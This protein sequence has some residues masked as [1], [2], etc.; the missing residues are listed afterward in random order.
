[1]F[2]EIGTYLKSHFHW[3]ASPL[4]LI[5]F[6]N[7][8]GGIPH[9]PQWVLVGAYACAV[10]YL[11]I[12]KKIKIEKRW[13]LILAY[14]PINILLARPNSV[15]QP[16]LR[17]AFF[18]VLLLVVSPM[19][20]STRA[21]IFRKQCLH[22]ISFLC[23]LLGAASFVAYFAGVNFFENRY[24][25]GYI[26]D[27][28]GS[29]GQF[30]GL[31]SHS[32]L[33]G[34]LSAVGAVYLFYYVNI[35][36]YRWLWMP[37]IMCVGSSF[38]AASRAAIIAMVV[39]A[40][41]LIYYSTNYKT[42]F[43]KRLF[44]ICICLLMSFPLWQGA[45]AGLSKKQRARSEAGGAFDSRTVKVECRVAEF[46][47]SPIVGVGFASIDPRGND[48][49]NWRTGTCEPGSS[50]LAILSMTGIA[51][52]L[53]LL[54]IFIKAFQYGKFYMENFWMLGTLSFFY[55]HMAVEGYIFA[56]GSPLAFILW[57]SIG[58]CYET[59]YDL[60]ELN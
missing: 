41:A 2:R 39:G 18:A 28:V 24:E 30:S 3:V 17:Y 45:T 10:L 55:V 31:S 33:L 42:I 22:N 9:L 47:S 13:L 15:F 43:V 8:V 36:R 53:I 40:V 37:L 56:A 20:K 21:R 19:I 27:Y 29:A 60:I 51:G 44:V 11:V 1:M 59:K 5:V 23:V 58:T 16:W 57:L 34:P 14:I 7:V 32:M 35:R 50:W 26:E 46:K 54:P 25:G 4:A 6:S 49:F 38:F 12:D 52:L 48:R